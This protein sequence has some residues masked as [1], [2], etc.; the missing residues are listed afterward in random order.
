MV[1]MMSA[2]GMQMVALGYLTY[3]LTKDAFILGIVQSGYGPSILVL[4]LFGGAIA[5]RWDRKRI[6][7]LAQAAS[8]TAALLIAVVVA[9]GHHTWIH[10]LMLSLFEGITFSFLGPARQAIIPEIVGRKRLTSAMALHGAGMS[11]TLLT[12]PA[13]AGVIYGRY[14][15]EGVFFVNAGL[16]AMAAV[17]TSFVPSR[18][19]SRQEAKDSTLRDIWA[20]LAYIWRTRLV[21]VLL[22]MGTA[23]ALFSMP[24]RQ[25]LPVLIVDV[26]DRGP[27]S[28]GLML[29]IG[30][31]GS[32]LG[33]GVIASMAAGRRGRLLL[34]AIFISGIGLMLI[35]I[36]PLYF[37]AVGF[38]VLMGMG[39]TGRRTLYQVILMDKV[40]DRFRGRVMSVWMLNFGLMPLGVLP[41]GLI[42]EH[43]GGQVA[44]GVLATCVL[45][46][47][48]V[49]LTTQRSIWEVR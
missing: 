43:F 11:V 21:L 40:E 9:T 28:M 45:A 7:M 4:V 19:A 20:G 17:M 12:I 5:D 41:A 33:A 47:G 2:W 48:L 16:A 3:D 36:V 22:L 49:V 30:G 27:E 18:R 24:F 44:V 6:I 15:P 25:I 14:G 1:C 29:S 35:A 26:Y 10:L 32:L 46:T 23:T 38:M 37:A 42:A 31:I 8:A 34:L 39:D 13:L